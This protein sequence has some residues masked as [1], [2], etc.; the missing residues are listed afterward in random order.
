M[1]SRPLLKHQYLTINCQS[2]ITGF[3]LIELMVVISILGILTAIGANTILNE[4]PKAKQAEAKASVAHIN[5]AQSNYWLRH[6]RFANNMNDLAIGLPISTANY[7]Y[8]ISGNS[9]LAT[10]NA[11]PANTALKGYAGVAEQYADANKQAIVSSIICEAA[12]PGNITTLPT[13]GRPGTGACNG[14]V[15]LGQ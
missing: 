7:T 10:V 8:N 12:A 13:S 1:K 15:E 4:V 3:T 9:I 5:S 14:D 6:G 11:V 2:N